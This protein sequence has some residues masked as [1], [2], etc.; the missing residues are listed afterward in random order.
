MKSCET[1]N[2]FQPLTVR[3]QSKPDAEVS[4]E[5][6]ANP[7]VIAA[8]FHTPTGATWHAAFAPIMSGNWCRKYEARM[9]IVNKE[10]V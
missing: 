5:C 6:H 4:G 2:A 8:T 10:L 1:C 3:D 7:P 9:S